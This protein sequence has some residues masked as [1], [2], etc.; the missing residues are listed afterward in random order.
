M[1]KENNTRRG[2]IRY[3]VAIRKIARILMFTVSTKAAIRS[4][5]YRNV[6]FYTGNIQV[7]VR[8][9]MPLKKKLFLKAR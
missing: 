4:F 9:A 7:F 1:L 3:T 6:H 2:F 5:V 8:T